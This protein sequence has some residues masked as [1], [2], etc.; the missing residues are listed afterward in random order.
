MREKQKQLY[1]NKNDY[2]MNLWKFNISITKDYITLGLRVLV[3]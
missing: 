1:A 2:L 3:L